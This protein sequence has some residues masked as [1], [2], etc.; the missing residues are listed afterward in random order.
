[1][2]YFRVHPGQLDH[3][4]AMPRAM[5]LSTVEAY[6]PRNLHEPRRRDFRRVTPPFPHRTSDTRRTENSDAQTGQGTA[7]SGLDGPPAPDSPVT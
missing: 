7:R 4:P 3:R 6:V 1:M 5:G 2:H